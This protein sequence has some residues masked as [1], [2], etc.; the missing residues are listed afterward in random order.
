M[1]IANRCDRSRKSI[2]SIIS[3]IFMLLFSILLATCAAPPQNSAG[4]CLDSV[5]QPV[6]LTMYYSSEKQ[7][8]IEAA[9]K[10]F[11]QQQAACS[12]PITIKATAMGSGQSMQRI[13][14]GGQPDI[15]SPASEIWLSLLN[16]MWQEK[17]PDTTNKQYCIHPDCQVISMGA[18]D[19]P[20]LVLSPLVIAM[21]KPEAEALGWPHKAL[22]WADI[23]ALSTS[24]QGWAAYGHPE[25]GDFKLGHTTPDNSNAGID[26]L[27]AEYYTAVGKARGLTVADI[28][29]TQAQ[30]FVTNLES[31]ITHYE[32]SSELLADNMFKQG[33]TYLDAI[34]TYE[35]LVVQANQ[36]PHLPFPVVAIYPKEGT[37]YS[38]HPF[39]ILQAGWVTP[40][41][42]AAALLFRTFLLAPDQQKKALRY[43]FRPITTTIKLG[44][45]LDSN[46]GVDPSQ[47]GSILPI[48]DQD[49]VNS[50]LTAWHKLYRRVDV[51]LLVDCSGS[52]KDPFGDTSKIRAVGR[53]ITA[54]VNS[55]SESD[56]VGLNAFSDQEVTLMP[57]S[58]LHSQRQEIINR[59]NEINPAGST[60]LYGS[61][62]DEV[63][64]LNA[65]PSRYPRVLIVFTDGEDT[66]HQLSLDQLITQLTSTDT[67]K[68][69]IFTLAYSNVSADSALL[70][71]IA[72]AA[73]GQEYSGSVAHAQELSTSLSQPLGAS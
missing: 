31:S 13:L 53:D 32:D 18:A 10:D 73:G 24:A 45:P 23:A 6:A 9:I 55:L 52:M 11:K 72:Q 19:T 41:K 50:I 37:F 49:V 71:R 16:Q 57:L 42:K 22:G 20:S 58:V 68:V 25:W 21:W 3:S 14:N 44:A 34:I 12:H 60:R 35:G 48:P 5:S 36:R 8:W 51:Q 26:A 7:A 59:V 4:Q 40:T 66:A 67:N 69:K 27:I 54:L 17:H 62:A 63:K 30:D 1:T 64:R 15:W 38:D 56:Y 65:L 47:P 70:T 33:P 43:G 39:T 28:Q 61:I 29:S 46:H 2:G